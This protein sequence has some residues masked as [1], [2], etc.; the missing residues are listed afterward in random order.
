MKHD[1]ASSTAF[2][3]VQ[4]ILKVA[5]DPELGH[6]VAP[7]HV[8][9][10]ERILRGSAEGRRRLA[11][12]DS[13]VFVKLTSL[14]ERLLLPGFTA[15]YVLR[16]RFIEDEVR[17]ALTRGA[18]QVIILGAGFDAL[19]LRLA[20]GHPDVTFIE[21]DH[22]ATSEVKRAAL[23]ETPPNLHLL[24][25][26]LAARPLR[27]VLTESPAFSA[28]R[29][30]VFVCEGVMM[31]LG[32][33][34]V[35]ELFSSIRSLTGPGT[36]FVFTAVAPLGSPE[37]NTSTILRA[38]LKVKSEPITWTLR[39]GDMQAF[40]ERQTYSM[41]RIANDALLA[42]AYHGQPLNRRLHEGEYLVSTT[43]RGGAS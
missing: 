8:E 37:D 9:A 42:K 1:K 26:D 41:D 15:H 38:Y 24:A 6:L 30:T 31:Y 20:T 17:A 39:P 19:A 21:I 18:R 10:C 13:P 27:E 34:T 7:D 29:P 16:K 12:L 5:N 2:T 40:V 28:E 33:A 3:V 23:G 32:E 22:P 11:Q 35:E 14:V 4:G 43:A 25:Q 36:G